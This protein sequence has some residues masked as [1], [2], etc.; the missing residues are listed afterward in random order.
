MRARKRQ[1]NEKD[2]AMDKDQAYQ[3]WLDYRAESRAC[4]QEYVSFKEY[5]GEQ[6]EVDY[7]FDLDAVEA[8]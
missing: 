5:I 7:T 4:G 8:Y 6:E 1:R 2:K 3:D